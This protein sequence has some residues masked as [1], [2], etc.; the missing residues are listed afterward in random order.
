MFC[1]ISSLTDMTL[2]IHL[3]F[4]EKCLVFN[5]YLE[6]GSDTTCGIRSTITFTK[7]FHTTS[8]ENIFHGI[9][10]QT[11][12]FKN[13]CRSTIFLFREGILQIN[14]SCN[15]GLP[16]IF[17]TFSYF[18]CLEHILVKNCSLYF[19]LPH[20][21]IYLQTTLVQLYLLA[22]GISTLIITV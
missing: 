11:T 17:T 15:I 16:N 4:T 5:C 14:F 9:W 21:C 12:K 3:Y 10:P 19:L 22:I 1:H 2:N 7:H 20:S 18:I 8:Y 6:W 13:N